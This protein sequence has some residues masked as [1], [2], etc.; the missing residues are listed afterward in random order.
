MRLKRIKLNSDFRSLKSGFELDFL[1]KK[2]DTL[3][4][5]PYCI[6]GRNGSGKSNI[7]ELLASIFYNIELSLL[8]Y[9]PP[10]LEQL[11]IF[12]KDVDSKY[13]IE[14]NISYSIDNNNSI[15]YVRESSE[16]KLVPFN[17][18]TYKVYQNN[19]EVNSREELAEILP[20]KLYEIIDSRQ[21]PNA[22]E[23]EYYINQASVRIIKNEHS[24]YQFY[25][26]DK[27]ATS[28][29]EIKSFL[30]EY[31]VGYS[32]GENEIL[33][34]PFFKMRLIQFDEPLADSR[35]QPII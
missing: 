34:L 28:E 8:V 20:W 13:F 23:L 21:S 11:V 16:I 29:Q 7:L 4:V 25:I 5:N 17:E 33:S 32:S 1:Y 27:L 2:P 14:E 15:K 24:Y 6:V 12:K 31:V 35:K 9:K 10:V 19:R 26:D 18:K 30:P 22:Y 3:E